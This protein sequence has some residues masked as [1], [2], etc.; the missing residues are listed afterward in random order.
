MAGQNAGRVRRMLFAALTAGTLGGCALSTRNATLVYPPPDSPGLVAVANAAPSATAREASIVV[1]PFSDRRP[2]KT[3]LGNVRNGFGIKLAPIR[4]TDSVTVW[5]KNALALEL[6]KAGFQVTDS[7]AG[8]EASLTIGGDVLKANAD[9]YLSY[10]AQVELQVRLM[11]GDRE[12]F[13]RPY[14]GK[15]SGGTN[16]T[17][18][19][20]SF[21][22]T[23]ARAL[24]DALGMVV[25][26]VEQAVASD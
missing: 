6:T 1:L 22:N 26:D 25:G 16:W 8:S 15:G 21:A 9:A 5:V 24:A 23:L 10:G 19:S 17:A 7:A 11:Q 20:K 12:L 14:L 13:S 3:K 18:T 2:D 4:T